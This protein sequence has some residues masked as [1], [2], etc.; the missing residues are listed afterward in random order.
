M[1][2]RFIQVSLYF[3]AGDLLQTQRPGAQ[4]DPTAVYFTGTSF[5]PVTFNPFLF[6][7]PQM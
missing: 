3:G 6:A 7:Y 1:R 4:S 2:F 5:R